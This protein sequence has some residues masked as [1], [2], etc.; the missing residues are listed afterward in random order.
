MYTLNIDDAIE[1]ANREFKVILAN[2]EP[3]EDYIKENKCLF[4]LHGDANDVLKY[5]KSDQKIFTQREY[6]KS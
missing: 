2:K 1:L 6:I 4:K 3:H 5:Q